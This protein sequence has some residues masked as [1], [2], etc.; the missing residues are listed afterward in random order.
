VNDE[1]LPESKRLAVLDV[2][3][4]LAQPGRIGDMIHRTTWRE[5]ERRSRRLARVLQGLGIV[6][7]ERVGSFAWNL[8]PPRTILRRVGLGGILHTINP[9]LT[10][11]DIAYIASHAGTTGRPK[12]LCLTFT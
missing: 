10:L 4:Q 6:P 12:V 3:G 2:T 9:R 1:G 7:G 8:P 11:D 5:V